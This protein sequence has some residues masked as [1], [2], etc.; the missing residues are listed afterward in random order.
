MKAGFGPLFLRLAQASATDLP[1][2]IKARRPATENP[3][4]MIAAST[5]LGNDSGAGPVAS[6]ASHHKPG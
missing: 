1:A 3:A 4:A 2:S 5:S 6:A